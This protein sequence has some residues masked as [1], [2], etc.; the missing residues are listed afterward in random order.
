MISRIIINRTNY[1][2]MYLNVLYYP[3]AP[4]VFLMYSKLGVY[5]IMIKFIILET[6]KQNV[7]YT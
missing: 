1:L 4:L 3:T 5:S 7:S 6:K 2:Y